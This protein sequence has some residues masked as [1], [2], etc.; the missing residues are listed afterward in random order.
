MAKKRGGG[1]SSPGLVI[2]LVFF[3]LA[4]MGLGYATYAGFAEQEGLNKKIKEEDLAKAVHS[5]PRSGLQRATVQADVAAITEAYRHIGR[6]DVSVV[7]EVIDRGNDSVD[8]VY[9]ITE[10]K[11]ATVRKIQFVGN[12]A[13]GERQL[14]A[15]IKT[16]TT[17][18]L[19][20]L[21]GGDVYDPD[22]VEQDREQIRLYYS[23]HGYADASVAAPVVEY[24]ESGG[25]IIAP[26]LSRVNSS[27]WRHLL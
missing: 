4:T 13:F 22:L 3:I 2:T 23:N 26:D 15:I 1:G 12:S 17:S 6:D 25:V 21:M 19:S 7:P 8:L 9:T 11:K 16:S 20:F 27:S 24:D 18:M 10:G 5:K 14:K